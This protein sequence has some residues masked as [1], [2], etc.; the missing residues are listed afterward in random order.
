MAEVEIDLF[1]ACRADFDGSG[2]LNPQDIV[3]F[4]D[5][6]RAGEPRADVNDD[7]VIGAHDVQAFMRL[8]RDGCP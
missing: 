7:G 2:H 4:H 8:Y 3:A 6:R 5:A 1:G